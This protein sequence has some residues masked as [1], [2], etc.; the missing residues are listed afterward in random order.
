MEI[1]PSAL[2]SSDDE[3]SFSR[4]EV[5]DPLT[6]LGE[7]VNDGFL[8]VCDVVAP[9]AG[10]VAVSHHL[11]RQLRVQVVTAWEEV[12]HQ[13]VGR[14]LPQ[15]ASCLLPAVFPVEGDELDMFGVPLQ[16]FHVHRGVLQAGPHEDDEGFQTGLLVEG[17]DGP[18][19]GEDVGGAIVSR[20]VN[21]RKLEALQVGG[22]GQRRDQLGVLE[23][24]GLPFYEVDLQHTSYIKTNTEKLSDLP[25]PRHHRENL[26]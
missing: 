11:G 6:G 16:S 18:G 10:G 17:L 21:H 3:F 22:E 14:G 8:K 19:E 5:Q 1:I 4:K 20:G 7:T 2:S 25:W 24:M 15:L 12:S 9:E 26:A 13:E 23:L